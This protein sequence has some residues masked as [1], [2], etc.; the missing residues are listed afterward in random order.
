[1][2]S[3]PVRTIPFFMYIALF[4]LV[5]LASSPDLFC[6]GSST[7]RLRDLLSVS[8][9]AFTDDSVC[10]HFKPDG[11][12]TSDGTSSVSPITPGSCC[13]SRDGSLELLHCDETIPLLDEVKLME[14]EGLG[15]S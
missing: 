3:S 1:M 2:A 13:D 6:T 12:V 5:G 15:K 7:L 10:S 14:V 11:G 8:S 9:L 4:S